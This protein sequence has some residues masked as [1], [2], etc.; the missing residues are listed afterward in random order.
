MDIFRLLGGGARFDKKRFQHDVN[1]FESE[2][3]AI[4][5]HIKQKNAAVNDPAV[6]DQ[7]LQ[8]IDFFNNT[9]TTD[10]EDQQNVM[11]KETS[12]KLKKG[13]LSLINTLLS[14]TDIIHS[15]KSIIDYFRYSRR[16]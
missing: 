8:E 5:T 11:T 7:L 1:L 2:K 9:T 16:S 4:R 15:Q 10:A 6:R 13:K 12:K 14:L 3:E